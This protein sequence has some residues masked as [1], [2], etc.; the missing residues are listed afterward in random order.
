LLERNLD[1]MKGNYNEA[2]REQMLASA[3][4]QPIYFA[5]RRKASARC[6]R[7]F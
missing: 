4:K 7:G 5:R 2:Q 1:E 6:T 3:Q